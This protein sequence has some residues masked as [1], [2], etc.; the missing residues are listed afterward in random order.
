MAPTVGY[1]NN[2]TAM[3]K[4]EIGPPLVGTDELKRSSNSADAKRTTQSAHTDHA[5]HVAVRWLTRPIPRLCCLARSVTT[6]LY[7]TTV[8]QTLRQTLRG[9]VPKGYAPAPVTYEDMVVPGIWTTTQVISPASVLMVNIPL[10][11]SE[12]HENGF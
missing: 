8:C 3:Y 10:T 1:A 11:P 5:I 9:E 4:L 2:A 7:R 12:S 6:P